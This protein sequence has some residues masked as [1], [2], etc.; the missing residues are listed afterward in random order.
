[1]TLKD[2]L[3]IS[4]R[5]LR[6]IV[7]FSVIVLCFSLIYGLG[8]KKIYSSKAQLLIRLGQEQLGSMQFMNNAKSVYVTRREQEMKNEE[9]IFLSDKVITSTAKEILGSDAEDTKV[10]ATTKKYLSD[11][12]EVKSLLASDTLSVTFKFPDPIAAKK[13]LEILIAKYI[14]HHISVFGNLNELNFV[15]SKLDES[16]K[17]YDEALTKYTQFVDSYKIY[18]EKQVEFLITKCNNMRSEL[19]NTNAEY[20]YHKEKLS[21]S[22][23]EIKLLRPYEKYNSVE[24]INDRR[25]RLKSKLNE[26]NMEKQN[27]LQKY[28]PESR[29]VLD[30]NK[31]IEMIQKLIKEEPERVVNTIDS[32]KN[33]TYWS[34]DQSIV[35]LKTTIAGEEAKIAS[36]SQG[37]KAMEE[38][39]ARSARD[40]QYFT[41]LK[42]DLDLAKLTYEKYYEG[43]LESDLNNMSKTQKVTNISLIEEP[44]VAF[45]PDWPKKGKLFLFAGAFLAA[46]NFFL[47]LILLMMN[48]SITN[49]LELEKQFG[50][51]PVATIPLERATSATSEPWFKNILTKL[52]IV[53]PEEQQ[54]DFHYFEKNLREFQRLF[55]NLSHIGKEEKIFLIGRSRPGEGGTTITFNLAVFLSQYL[56]KKIAFI[57]YQTSRVTADKKGFEAVPGLPLEKKIVSHVDCYRF[58]ETAS[59]W[60]ADGKEKFQFLESLRNEYDYIFCNILPIKDSADL[61]FLNHYVDRILFYVE[62]DNTK[63]QIVKYNFDLLAQ[64]GF[65]NISFILNKRRYFIPKFLYKYV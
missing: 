12:L 55:V 8:A 33:D 7:I 1:M 42:K 9:M 26:A 36:L 61:V 54:I 15:K 23:Q 18:D 31:E 59:T 13:I 35:D 32:R 65:S 25:N 6:Y 22:E 57:D 2:I 47:V 40:F 48:N 21:R 39:L 45:S 49:P 62:A 53:E 17:K 34:M 16:R 60:E 43:Y 63:R 14:E 58:V 37:L 19:A 4:F 38:E 41:L 30:V 10:L 24:I 11:H 27:L 52:S 46:G 5:Y 20:L 56:D 3:E 50:V 44:S 29:L 64:Y 51:H 28:T